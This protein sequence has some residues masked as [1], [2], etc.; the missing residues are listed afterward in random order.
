MN[1]KLFIFLAVFGIKNRPGLGLG[2]GL[3]FR[4][5]R[6]E[7]PGP[8]QGRMSTCTGHPMQKLHHIIIPDIHAHNF[9]L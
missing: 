1:S 2:L 4:K 7:E 8:G 5:A 9:P 6:K 3:M